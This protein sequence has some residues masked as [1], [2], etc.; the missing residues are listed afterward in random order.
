VISIP[1]ARSARPAAGLVLVLLATGCVSV[2]HTMLARDFRGPPVPADEVQ[3]Y[4]AGEDVPDHTRVAVLTASGDTD[5]SNDNDL[6]KKLREKAGKLGAN[7]IILGD[8]ESPS[9][10][11]VALKALADTRLDRRAVAVAVF[12]PSLRPGPPPT[13]APRR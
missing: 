10:G 5:F 8:L 6:V 11:A 9:A 3:V 7:A 1:P 2:K 13:P 12:V 4:L